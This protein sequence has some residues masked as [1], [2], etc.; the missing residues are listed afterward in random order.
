LVMP[1]WAWVAPLIWCFIPS[2]LLSTKPWKPTSGKES[3][4][5]C[6]GGSENAKRQQN[7]WYN[8]WGELISNGVL[9]R[10]RVAPSNW[11]GLVLVVLAS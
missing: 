5:A 11:S 1:C 10:Y 8:F 3:A 4:K 6:Y 7:T 9:P 2:W